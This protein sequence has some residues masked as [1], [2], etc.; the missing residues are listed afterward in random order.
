MD[1]PRIWGRWAGFRVAHQICKGYPR[2][3]RLSCLLLAGREVKSTE[4]RKRTQVQMPFSTNTWN[5]R[6]IGLFLVM[7]APAFASMIDTARD[8]Y[9]D[10]VMIR[11]VTLRTEMG[12]L[13]TQ[14]VRR[15]GRLERFL[16]LDWSDEEPTDPPR[17]VATEDRSKLL[18]N[19]DSPRVTAT[20]ELY[21]AIVDPQGLVVLHS[22][23][24]ASGK[25]LTSEWDDDKQL[26]VGDDVVRVRRGALSGDREAYDLNL[27]LTVNGKWVGTLHSGLDASVIDQQVALEQQTLLKRRFWIVGLLVMINAS[28]IL[29]VIYLVKRFKANN[30]S[31]QTQ[32]DDESRKLA[33]I[34]LGLAHEVR[35][36]L[37]ALRINTHT[38]RRSLA[39]KPLSEQDMS[40]MMRE[41]C[42]EI[43]RIESLMRA[44][45][46]YVAPQSTEKLADVELDRETQA[47]L[48]LQSDELRRRR[49][50]VSFAAA[51]PLL[52]VSVAPSQIR[53]ILHELFTFAQRS[54]GEGGKLDV[55]LRSVENCAELIITDYGR[56]LP[57]SDLTRLFEPF[58]ATAYSEAGLNLALIQRHVSDCGGSLKRSQSTGANRFELRLPLAHNAMKGIPS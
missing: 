1:F 15:A 47:I 22:E 56:E 49:I 34:G 46:Q 18:A 13:R 19:W 48:Q 31:L 58:H 53:A 14:L 28:A 50:E 20:Q 2:R 21:W 40:D 44:L 43:D 3:N 57:P 17:T 6:S 10:T 51:K 5:L 23:P 33:Q 38:L 41:S 24:A 25:R 52:V 11:A 45:V 55:Q 27:P 30:A 32:Q 29:G 39:G 7:I 35:N 4:F 37:H 42:D 36:P 16:E 26:E 12:H 9:C 54:A 8:L